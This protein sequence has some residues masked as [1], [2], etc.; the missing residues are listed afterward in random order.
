MVRVNR[1]NMRSRPG[2]AGAVEAPREEV[3]ESDSSVHPVRRTVSSSVYDPDALRAILVRPA[4]GPRSF[5]QSP[6]FLIT[7]SGRQGATFDLWR[8][9]PVLTRPHWPVPLPG[10]EL[11]AGTAT[12]GTGTL[13]REVAL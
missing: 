11:V 5:S 4:A 9:D 3:V 13:A 10:S 2:L 8:P 7:G 6:S 12:T 1:R